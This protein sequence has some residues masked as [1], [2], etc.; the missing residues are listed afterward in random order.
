M[1]HSALQQLQTA[2]AALANARLKRQPCGRI[3]EAFGIDTLTGAYAVQEIN[4]HLALEAGRRL[5]GRKVGLT[6]T[7]V[8]QQLGV[9]QPDFG[10]LFADMEV[11]DGGQIDTSK[12]IQPKAEGEI[13]FVLG[14]DLPNAD[15]TLAE[16]LTAVDYVLPA[17]EIVDSAIENWKI[18][19]VD[20]VADNA[21]S[22]LYVLGKQP[23][24]LSALD[25]RLEGMLLEKNGAQASIGVGAACLGNPVDACLWLARTMAEIGRPLQAGDVLLS[26]ALG[27]MTPVVAGD[28]LHLRLTR[29][30]E[31]SCRF[32]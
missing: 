10:M 7:A 32:V 21:S 11:V 13:A 23:T 27:P 9:D 25:L 16:L 12:L 14:R 17:L 15:T 19:L 1:N 24:K 28:S 30:G 31:V 4:T 26:G 2:A 22:A 8:Q 5:V 18:T 20:T 29:L 3:S 6:S